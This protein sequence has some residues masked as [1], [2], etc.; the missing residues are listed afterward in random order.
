MSTPESFEIVFR[1]DIQLGKQLADVKS[2]LQQLFKIDAAKVEALFSGKPVVLKRG[3]DKAS[4]EKYQDALTKAGALVERVAST[5][6]LSAAQ[7]SSSEKSGADKPIETIQSDDVIASTQWTLAPVGS[8]ML[9]ASARLAPVMRQFDL[10]IYSLRPVGE[11]L[12]DRTESTR[13][14][15]LE[16]VVIPDYQIADVGVNLIETSEKTQ[17]PVLDIHI[18][19]WS[20]SEPGALLLTDNEKTLVVSSV[21]SPNY[22]LAP[23]GSLLEQIKPQVEINIPD[24]SGLKILENE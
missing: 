1:G 13:A 3:L 20:L 7:P 2:A 15:E 12:L 11:N 22:S 6:P 17:T 19:D 23:V 24:V 18:E 21:V 9:P 4:A 16:S 8:L 5:K 14:A 10:K